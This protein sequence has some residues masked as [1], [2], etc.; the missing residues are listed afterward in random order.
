MKMAAMKRVFNRVSRAGLGKVDRTSARYVQGSNQYLIIAVSSALPFG[1]FF[2]VADAGRLWP[3]A[4]IQAALIGVWL[5]C[6]AL[7]VAGWVRTSSVIEL[8]APMVAFTALAWL[9]SYR[10]GFL[11]PMLMTASVSF[12]TF[13]PRMLRWG[14][15][16]TAAS[17]LTVAWSFLDARMAEP[18]IDVSTGMINGLLIGN[19]AL[20]TVVMALTSALNHHYL[21]RE[22]RRAERQLE[23][24][25]AQARTD[26]LTM[27]TNRRGMSELL[28]ALNENQSYVMAL[29]DLDRF[30]EVN[31]K[32]GHA[33]GDVVLKAVARVLEESIGAEGIV[34]RWGAR[35]SS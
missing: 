31:D 13:A 5:G 34:S 33:H 7:N 30:K 12:V 23:N 10:A 22:R 19:V 15:A 35:S 20:V 24:A 16:L 11:L 8:I 1:V 32:L 2:L 3:A 6:F 4:L 25:E 18:R 28:A 26:P 9:L 14:I 27:L 17:A 29:V 21:S